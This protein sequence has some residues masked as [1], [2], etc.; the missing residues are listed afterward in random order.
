[1][2]YHQQI[3]PARYPGSW[4]RAV[5]QMFS[6]ATSPLCWRQKNTS[7]S[8]RKYQPFPTTPCSAGDRPVS[9][10]DW[11]VQVTA[12]RT[13]ASSD[14]HPCAASLVRRGIWRRACAVSPTTSS[15]STGFTVLPCC[16]IAEYGWMPGVRRSRRAYDAGAAARRWDSA[17]PISAAIPSTMPTCPPGRTLQV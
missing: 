17:H 8:S 9:M 15:S 10:V 1:M 5:S 16:L 14:D 11:T 4:R 2:A 3:F 12:G 6:P 7:P 13:V